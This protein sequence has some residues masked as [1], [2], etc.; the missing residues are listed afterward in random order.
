MYGS[1]G[2]KLLQIY[3]RFCPC[4]CRTHGL[5]ALL[6]IFFCNMKPLANCCFL[7]MF[8]YPK[9]KK[10]GPNVS[11]SVTLEVYQV[12]P[13]NN[14]PDKRL[15]TF[16]NV[17]RHTKWQKLMLPTTALQKLI[18][19]QDKNA[20]RTLHLRVDCIQCK[21]DVLWPVMLLKGSKNNPITTK[22][23]SKKSKRRAGKRS[24]RRRKKRRNHGQEKKMNKRRPFIVMI[25]QSQ[26]DEEAYNTGRSII[27]RGKRHSGECES[28]PGNCCMKTLYVSFKELGWDSWILKPE[29]YF[30]N[31]CEGKCPNI[32]LPHE[33]AQR[34]S[35]ILHLFKHSSRKLDSYKF[36]CSPK[37]MRPLS[38]LYINED[39]NMVKTT[40]ANMS[41]EKCGCA[42]C[43]T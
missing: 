1:T 41:V 22:A 16:T 15:I 4:Y 10:G 14:R 19:N 37:K 21:Q 28:R 42:W 31:Y 6:T 23:T 29:G 36:C 40:L 8:Q 7:P 13:E 43:D 11:K 3:T 9:Q 38:L 33:H 32:L 17:V 12:Y 5:L 39:G 20:P 34:H 18:D 27:S 25:A 2:T 26:E 24:Q 35:Q 30:A